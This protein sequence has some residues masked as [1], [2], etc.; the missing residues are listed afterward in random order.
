MAVT[1]EQAREIVREHFEPGWSMGTFCLDD[2]LITENDEFY[3]FNVGARE[4]IV[5]NDS[6]YAAPGG[7]P[8]VFKEDGRLGGRPSVLLVQDPSIRTTPNPNPTF[9]LT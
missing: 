1:Y 7:V 9:T 4:F 5:D 2:R 6:S 8:I 3:V